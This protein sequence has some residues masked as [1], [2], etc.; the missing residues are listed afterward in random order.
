VIETSV[1]D[2]VEDAVMSTQSICSVTSESED[3]DGTVTV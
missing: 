3:S 2:I 1:V